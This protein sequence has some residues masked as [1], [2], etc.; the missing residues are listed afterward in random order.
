MPRLVSICEIV[1]KNKTARNLV[2]SFV[3]CQTLTLLAAHIPTSCVLALAFLSLQLCNRV[4]GDNGCRWTIKDAFRA[5]GRSLRH[6]CIAVGMLDPRLGDCGGTTASCC[7]AAS[8]FA[9]AWR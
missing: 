5:L 4:V 1:R 2:P 8:F 9:A 3:A 7:G 6:I